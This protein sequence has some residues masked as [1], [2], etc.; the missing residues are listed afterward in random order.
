MDVALELFP[1]WI[2]RGVECHLWDGSTFPGVSGHCDVLSFPQPKGFPQVHDDIG[3][4]HVRLSNPHGNRD[5][6]HARA[7]H[8]NTMAQAQQTIGYRDILFLRLSP[9]FNPMYIVGCLSI[10]PCFKF[11]TEF[12]NFP[13]CVFIIDRPFEDVSL[14]IYLNIF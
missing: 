8:H 10:S 6:S 9:S 12:I 1:R 11:E 7:D 4:A 13:S 2:P 14:S 5:C 3:R